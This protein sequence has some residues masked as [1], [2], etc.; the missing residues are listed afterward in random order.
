M[1]TSFKQLVSE[2]VKTED[3]MDTRL[4]QLEAVLNQHTVA[5]DHHTALLTQIL[6]RLPKNP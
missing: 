6:D 5:L 4:N 1:T 2:Q 3:Q